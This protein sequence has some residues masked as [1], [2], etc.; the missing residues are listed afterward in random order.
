MRDR[1]SRDRGA[2]ATELDLASLR[3]R[4]PVATD[5]LFDAASSAVGAAVRRFAEDDED[6]QELAQGAWHRILEKLPRLAHDGNPVGWCVIVARNH[7][8]SVLRRRAVEPELMDLEEAAG[9]V[10]GVNLQPAPVVIV[11][12]FGTS[13]VNLELRVWVTEARA[14]RRI[15]DEITARVL[16]GFATEGVEIP[17]P[18]RELYIREQGAA[19]RLLP[20]RDASNGGGEGA[21]HPR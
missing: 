1:A 20:G 19:Q 16:V 13:E 21:P 18:K 2:R 4:D 14:R 15:A 6:A 3:A 11:R 12:G 10:D 8:K 17:Y 5:K 7:C 9:K